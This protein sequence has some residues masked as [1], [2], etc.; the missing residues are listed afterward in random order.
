VS[1]LEIEFFWTLTERKKL[2]NEKLRERALSVGWRARFSKNDLSK[3]AHKEYVE[4]V[5]HKNRRD[6]KRK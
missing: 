6:R 3:Q 2:P 5:E 4:S 1:S